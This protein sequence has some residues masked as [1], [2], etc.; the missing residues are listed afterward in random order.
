MKENETKA[1]ETLSVVIQLKI[2]SQ[3]DSRIQNI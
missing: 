1:N 3:Q 2:Y